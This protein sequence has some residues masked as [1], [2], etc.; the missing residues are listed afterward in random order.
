MKKH[1]LLLQGLGCANCAAKIEERIR[2][3][4]GVSDVQMN[5]IAKKLTYF[6][7]PSVKTD[8]DI[9]RIIK[10]VEPH[11]IPVPL[12]FPQE[13]EEAD[14]FEIKR[15]IFG[16]VVF[17]I[18]LLLS[19][20]NPFRLPLFILAY[21][22]SGFNVLKNAAL[23]IRNGDLFNENFLMSIATVGAFAVGEYPEG[24]AVMLFYL[25]GEIFQD[26]AVSN[27][28]DS[29]RSLLDI[30]PDTATLLQDTMPVTV[31]PKSV[32][33]GD[34]ILVKPGE[35]IPLDGTIL[36]GESFLDTSALTGESV[37]L[38]VREGDSVLSGSINTSQAL[39]IHV[40][41][42]YGESTVSKILEL[43]ENATG[44]K[45][46]TEQYITKFARYY[47]PT[48]VFG[49]IALATLPPLFLRD[50]SF[51]LW[52]YRALIFLV[53]SCPCALVVSIPLGFFGGI[54]AASKRGILVKGSN[55]LEALNHAAVV[56]FDKTGT[57]TEGEFTV[58]TVLPDGISES[59]LIRLTALSETNSNHPIAQSIRA[60]AGNVSGEVSET[61]EISG[62]GIRAVVDGKTV[63]AGNKALFELNGIPYSHI[64]TDGTVVHVACDG[65]YIGS[66][67][68]SDSIKPDSRSA[69]GDLRSL[70][71]RNIVLLTGDR[72][73]PANALCKQLGMD[74]VESE[75]LPQDKVAF[76]EQMHKELQPKDKLLF[77]GDGI[78]DAPVLARADIGIAMGALGSDAAI[79]A[80]DIVL[81][82][83]EPSKLPVAIRI[84]KRTRRIV[85]QNIVF[86]LTVK[87][88]V[89]V[90]SA[91]GFASM[92]AAVFADVGVAV[93]AVMNSI[94]LLQAKDL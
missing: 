34:T 16:T 54:G 88:L 90:L 91:L 7:S 41:K 37:P 78:N 22:A 15:L 85:M 29:I 71:I 56:V 64:D 26:R 17:A 10:E 92:W 79:E 1:E 70:G 6:S 58:R 42:E 11:V 57:L 18:A 74:R 19:D 45:A 47:T 9:F 36:Q 12:D 66:I 38:H 55:F 86:A 4:E 33:P 3:L 89:L 27:S 2:S 83:D 60:Y 73:E 82:T 32:F 52:F 35:R 48:V 30:R 72:K 23:G 21:V 94:R 67:G 8:E 44:R 87:A 25:I 77:V 65:M 81:M 68:I 49:A 84:A 76:V 53:V 50:G 43:V 46:P 63:L 62:K 40:D 5:F 14:S 93:L 80:A 39:T 51:H 24:V 20:T 28:R 69:I 75:L 31:H 59:E 61:E 13:D